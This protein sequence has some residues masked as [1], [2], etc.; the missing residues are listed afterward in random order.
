MHYVVAM[1]I[2]SSTLKADSHLQYFL[3]KHSP[4]RCGK[5]AKAKPCSQR[6]LAT[7]SLS[8][9]GLCA[10]ANYLDN[11]DWAALWGG[12]I[13]CA[14]YT[15]E[16]REMR[17]AFSAGN[18]DRA[19]E[20]LKSSGIMDRSQDRLLWRLEAATILDRK[21]EVEKSRKLWLEADQ[22]ADELYTVSVSKTATS[23]V[24]SDGVFKLRMVF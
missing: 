4:S 9:K 18:Y 1:Q 13:S 8:T 22:V 23:F 20:A 3:A 21:G 6:L 17:E 2:A 10:S 19:L 24:M 16:T 15:D 14:S 11:S 7:G 5:Q 12:L